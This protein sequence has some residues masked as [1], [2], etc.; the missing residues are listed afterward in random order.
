MNRKIK[1]S[2]TRITTDVFKKNKQHDRIAASTS[3]ILRVLC[4]WN[5]KAYAYFGIMTSLVL[6]YNNAVLNFQFY[7]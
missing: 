5:I 3:Q 1:T 2:F 4:Y 6:D 7:I